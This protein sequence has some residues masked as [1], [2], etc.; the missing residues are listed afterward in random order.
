MK[1]YYPQQEFNGKIY[2]KYKNER[3]FTRG[4]KFMHREVWKFY[5]GD[6]PKGYHI[7]HIDGNPENND[8]SNLQMI[9]ASEHLSMEG[10]RR[11]AE[12]PEWSREFHLKGIAAAPKWHSS[13]EGK[14]WHKRHAKKF[15]FGKQTYGN[16]ECDVCG[17]E[18]VAKSNHQRFC[19]NKCKSKYRR[20]SGIDN[21]TIKCKSCQ[22]IFTKN[23]Y[24]KREFCCRKCYFSYQRNNSIVQEPPR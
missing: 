3:Y 13:K 9:E 12:N 14:E 21:I 24:E 19:S 7:H 4:I 15:N 17:T 10:K 5:N 22:T 2:R 23:K 1:K 16:R 11:H 8:I 18:F 20:D 6:I